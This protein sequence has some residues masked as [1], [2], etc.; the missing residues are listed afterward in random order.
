MGNVTVDVVDG[1]KA[2]G[3]ASSYAAAVAKA[4]GV[5]ACIVTAHGQDADLGSVFDVSGRMEGWVG[6]GGDLLLAVPAILHTACRD[7][8]D[9]WAQVGCAQLAPDRISACPPAGP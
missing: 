5:R 3:G 9:G 6:E 2:L 4:W 8:V 1:K 7:N